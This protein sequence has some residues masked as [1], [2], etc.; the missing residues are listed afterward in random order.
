[1]AFKPKRRPDRVVVPSTQEPLRRSVDHLIAKERYKDAVKQ[2]KICYKQESTPEHHYLLEH[3][4]FLR[5]AQLL[6]GAMP[7]AAQEVAQ[8]L[9]DFGITDPTLNEPV[10][11]LLLSVGMAD[12]AFALQSHLDTPEAR[13]RLARKAVDEAVL[14]SGLPSKSVPADI[15]DGAQRVRQALEALQVGDESKALAGLHDVARNSPF[16]DWRLF[17][18]GFAA[19]RRREDAEAQANW[20]RL[21]PDRAASKIAGSLL[22]VAG[23]GPR[24]SASVAKLAKL[25]AWACG[26]SV[27]KPLQRLGESITQGDWDEVISLLRTLRPALVRI[28]R[29]L[30]VRLTRILYA[31]LIHEASDLSLQDA[32]R[33]VQGV[34]KVAEPLPIDPRWNRLW[35]LLWEQPQGGTDQTET[36]WRV[37]Q[38]D[39]KTVEA[40]RPEERDQARA[41]VFAR[42]GGILLKD[43]A[44]PFPGLPGTIESQEKS[45]R[46]RAVDCFEESLR[47][48]PEHRETYQQLM[49]AFQE[50]KETDR[51]AEVARRLIAAFPD[52]FEALMFLATH[53][54]RREEPTSALDYVLRARALRPLDKEAISLEWSA[55]IGL[56]RHH[57]IAKRW[58]EA[59]AALA[60]AGRLMPEW[61]KSSHFLARKA[62]LELRAGQ[63]D[64][65]KEIIDT[66]IAS[67]VEPTPFWLLMA[68]ESRRFKLPKAEQERFD[69]LWMTSVAKKP[70]GETAGALAETMAGFVGGETNYP[71][72]NEHVKQVLDY[73]RRTTR[74][75]YRREDLIRVCSFLDLIKRESV[76]FEKLIKRGLKLFPKAPEFLLMQ[77]ALEIE[78][79]PF[80]GNLRLARNNF[81]KGIE[82]AKAEVADDRSRDEVISRLQQALSGLNDL[83]G[84]P[85]GLPFLGG[86]GGIPRDLM[87]TFARMMGEGQ[88]DPDDFLD[89]DFEDDEFDDLPLPYLPKPKTSKPKTPKK[90][91]K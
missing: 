36:Y 61:G 86:K 59:R 72:K 85:M 64:Q 54:T 22:S 34:A 63:I 37:Y 21:D 5:A 39:L 82:L 65:S 4:Y 7:N 10:A 91:K 12:R 89:D 52:D 27:L 18:R 19:F 6:H 73:I 9:L 20:T 47:L 16:A 88:I 15:R 28:D 41:L 74:I 31:P 42:L 71:G 49:E 80:N 44:D 13:E 87:D 57:A 45:L 77:G 38:D 46:Q 30:A 29:T 23:L 3:A 17:V 84:G 58:D 50:W 2:A 60:T 43:A 40:F 67:L 35:A 48:F 14:Q 56:A 66:A 53:E 55:R 81:E 8:H 75:K 70:L 25:E 83:M 33:L 79:G 32:T 90:P 1:M 11:K 51:A 68:I 69:A 62:A 26:E 76:L 24:D 78:K